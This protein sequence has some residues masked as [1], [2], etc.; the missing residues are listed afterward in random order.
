MGLRDLI[1]PSG[2]KAA[3]GTLAAT[4][5]FSECRHLRS[6]Q[7]MG[8]SVIRHSRTPM[9]TPI[10]ASAED[11]RRERRRRIPPFILTL[12]AWSAVVYLVEGRARLFAIPIVSIPYMLLAHRF[13]MSRCGICGNP[14][15]KRV[16]W[17][18][19]DTRT[20]NL[21]P[22]AEFRS[23]CASCGERLAENAV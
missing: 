13:N 9:A 12:I 14:F 6:L 19:P 3:R 23:S 2:E 11:L 17:A 10:F 18:S 21:D 22:R 4:L 15:F 7:V 1:S 5:I 8:H 16:N 20:L